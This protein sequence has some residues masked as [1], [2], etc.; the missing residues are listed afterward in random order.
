MSTYDLDH[1]P[2]SGARPRP[3]RTEAPGGDAGTLMSL[4]RLAG[5]SAVSRAIQDGQIGA[6]HGQLDI[7]RDVMTDE[8]ETEEEDFEG[9]AGDEEVASELEGLTDDERESEENEAEQEATDNAA[10]EAVDESEEEAK[11]EEGLEDTDLGDLEE[12][13]ESEEEG[14]GV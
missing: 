13:K 11:E 1:V 14:A 6:D 12:E 8:D 9:A 5:N 10:E 2:G 3:A 7:Q 4:Q